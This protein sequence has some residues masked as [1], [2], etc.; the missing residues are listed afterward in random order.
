LRSQ[1]L[2]GFWL[3]PEWLWQDPRP[4]EIV[5]LAAILGA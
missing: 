2:P 5:F 1:V 3:R 4:E